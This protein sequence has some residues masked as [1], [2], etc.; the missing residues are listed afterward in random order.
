[1]NRN[2][3]SVG[4]FGIQR[5]QRSDADPQRKQ[6]PGDR[7][8][9]HREFLGFLRKHVSDERHDRGNLHERQVARDPERKPMRVEI[10]ETDPEHQADE[11]V[12]QHPRHRAEDDE[13]DDQTAHVRALPAQSRGRQR[14]SHSAALIA[15]SS[16]S[17]RML[18]RQPHARCAGT[19]RVAHGPTVPRRTA[20]HKRRPPR[21]RAARATRSRTAATIDAGVVASSSRPATD[22]AHDLGAAADPARDHGRP[23][24]K[25][26]E[27]H[28]GHPLA[29]RG[30]HEDLAG[31]VHG[32]H[33]VGADAA[34]EHDAFR[35]A[36][37]PASARRF[38]SSGP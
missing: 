28:V 30:E 36:E 17:I 6:Q 18:M 16:G 25:A 1:M 21:G 26:L 34:A 38:R 9:V 31:R 23:A 37:P 7:Y 5:E 35:D 8:A 27:Q 19:R 29:C 2:H 10:S 22:I 4:A 13:H 32:R 14:F 3:S 33:Q 12:I 24:R 15:S 20:S 11:R